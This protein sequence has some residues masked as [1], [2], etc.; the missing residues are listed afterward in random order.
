MAEP[1]TPELRD[2]LALRLV[3]GLGPRLTAA[4]LRRFGS[5]TAVRRATASQLRQVP[6]IGT[7]LSLDFA[8]ALA[9]VDLDRECGLLEEHNVHLIVLGTPEYPTALAE[10]ADPPQLLFVRGNLTPTD[11][12]AVAIVGSRGCTGYGR[13]ITAGLAAGLVRAGY[14]VISG[15]PRGTGLHKTSSSLR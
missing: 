3:P 14:T 15:L 7:K 11:N 2:L 4:L 8:A 5:A 10:I 12:R 1:L 6:Q 9:A 13:R